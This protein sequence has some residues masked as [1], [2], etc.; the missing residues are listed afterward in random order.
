M[1]RTFFFVGIPSG[2]FFMQGAFVT[3]VR[4]Q[5]S[6]FGSFG[7][8]T[9]HMCFPPD[10]SEDGLANVYVGGGLAG[11][12]IVSTAA[13]GAPSVEFNAPSDSPSVKG[14]SHS[15]EPS[16]WK[17]GS[18]HS[19]SGCASKD[20]PLFRFPTTVPPAGAAPVH[21]SSHR[22]QREQRK[23]HCLPV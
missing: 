4:L 13:P 15:G 2:G 21:A 1:S 14:S 9:K 12:D 5:I 7:K 10:F 16:F 22:H 11:G 20:F 18:S 19:Y 23:R 3:L 8:C 17:K 6:Q